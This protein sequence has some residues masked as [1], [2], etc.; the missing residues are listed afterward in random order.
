MKEKH[1]NERGNDV[2]EK[3]EDQH[4]IRWN[5]LLDQDVDVCCVSVQ[6]K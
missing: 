4:D 1:W 2:I 5:L 6:Y 3:I